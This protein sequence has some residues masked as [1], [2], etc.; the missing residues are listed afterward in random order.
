MQR[1]CNSGTSEA[2]GG[3]AVDV[4][5]AWTGHLASALQRALRLSNER[6]AAHLGVA[7][8]TVAGWHER[9]GRIV[10]GQTSR[11]LDTVLERAKPNTRERF[12]KFAAATPDGSPA[13]STGSGLVI[14]RQA[15]PPAG[16]VVADAEAPMIGEGLAY[17]ERLED[18]V[19]G[20]KQLVQ[21][22]LAQQ[23]ATAERPVDPEIWQEVVIHWFVDPDDEPSPHFE[24][25]LTTASVDLVRATTEMFS[26][27][28][29]R[30]GG[31]RTRLLIGHVLDTDI[32]PTLEQVRPGAG[33]ASDYLGEVSALLR[34]AAWTAY[35]VGDQWLAQ[36]YF[37]DALRLAKAAGNRTLGGRIL[38]GMSHQANFLGDFQRAVDLARAARQGFQ[39]QGTPRALA[40]A[41]AMEARGLAS[42][43]RLRDC[44]AAIK[45]AERWFAK[46]NAVDEPAW[47]QYFDGAELHAEIAHCYR[48]L[49]RPED[50]CLHAEM[51]IAASESI[52]VRSLMFAQT[53]NAT[54]HLL[55]NELEQATNVARSVV[56][57]AVDQLR[58]GRV[59]AYVRDFRYRLAPFGDTRVAREFDEYL[60]A[61]L[62]A[63]WAQS[64]S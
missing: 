60:V 17:P 22:D 48:D 29:Y 25:G 43:G 16:V 6:F 15:T 20:L 5:D 56:D 24:E 26:G 28:D 35:D 38:A 3:D 54:G 21:L 58:S 11:D 12:A 46:S 55:R 61:R 2:W 4:I 19:R 8:R 47:L 62:G 13:V 30:F 49:G 63:S 50:A 40:L 14:P 57:T 10:R 1:Q 18:G 23:P 36:M 34:L 31:G 52:Y 9:P 45:E 41:W 7:T 51:C 37:T 59:L 39:N 44:E 64:V 27:H 53:V 33:L 32:M 42:M